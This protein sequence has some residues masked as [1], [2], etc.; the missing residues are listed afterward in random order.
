MGTS[1][2]DSCFRR[3]RYVAFDNVGKGMF[4][5]PN[6]DIENEFERTDYPVV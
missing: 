3:V 2:D 4:Q 5:S 6:P 1:F